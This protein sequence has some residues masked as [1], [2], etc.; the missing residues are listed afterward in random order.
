MITFKLHITCHPSY[1]CGS[2]C[3]KRS[4]LVKYEEANCWTVLDNKKESNANALHMGKMGAMHFCLRNG[5]EV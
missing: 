3:W 2:A 5:S 4:G 1:A